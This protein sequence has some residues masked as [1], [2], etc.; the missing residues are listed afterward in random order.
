MFVC[1][2][3]FAKPRNQ[4]GKPVWT[5]PSSLLPFNPLVLSLCLSMASSGSAQGV[6]RGKYGLR[7]CLQNKVLTSKFVIPDF[8]NS[9]ELSFF[10]CKM[11]TEEV[12]R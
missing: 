1:R 5:P 3:N 9:V 2:H 12:E 4:F 7:W 8:K 11:P 6:F 10:K